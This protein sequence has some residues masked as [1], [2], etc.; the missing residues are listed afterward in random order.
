MSHII[1]HWRDG[2]KI[3][4]FIVTK[5]VHRPDGTVCFVMP[6]GG[7]ELASYDELHFNLHGLI[8]A[9]IVAEAT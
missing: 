5:I 8:E 2:E 9:L 3:G 7:V 4:Q 6:P 1:E